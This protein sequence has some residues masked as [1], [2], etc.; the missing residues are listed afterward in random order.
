MII[1]VHNGSPW[2]NSCLESISQQNGIGSNFELTLS[3]FDDAS[4]DDTF[5]RLLEWE[6][7]LLE[8][9]IGTCFRKSQ[10]EKPKG[11]SSFFSFNFLVLEILLLKVYSNNQILS[12]NLFY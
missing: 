9:K 1:T 10:F 8:K 6:S 12:F 4:S 11:G 3:V 7:C 5:K 2:I